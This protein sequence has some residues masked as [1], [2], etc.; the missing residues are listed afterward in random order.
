MLTTRRY[1]EL[2]ALEGRLGIETVKIGSHG[3]DSL[4]GKLEASITRLLGLY[5]VVKRFAPDV[6]VTT[7]SPEAARISYGLGVP[8]LV[9]NDSPHSVAVARLVAPLAKGLY[10]PWL[11]RKSDWL[12]AGVIPENYSKYHAI[13]PVA[14]LRRRHLW[15]SKQ[16][17]EDAK[18]SVVI[19]AGESKAYYYRGTGEDAFELARLLSRDYEVVVLSRYSGRESS[20]VRVIGPG[21]FGPNVLE[22]ALAFVGFGGT[23]SQ[24]AILLGVPT[25]SA[26]P[27]EYR[28]EQ[29]LARRG[30]IF[31]AGSL[32]DAVD[33][34]HRAVDDT[35]RIRARAEAFNR[36]LVDPAKYAAH[37]VLHMV[38]RSS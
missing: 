29:E 2:D 15:P 12:A 16:S 23:M 36:G 13:D 37:E 21:F 1:D 14:W 34:V 25:I 19:R 8:L 35:R 20:N 30:F 18:N 33:L 22:G 32:R 38:S 3:G 9:F 24:E 7:A 11:I 6:T 17:W 4:E 28:L 26:Y 31:K 27:G 10:S 5:E